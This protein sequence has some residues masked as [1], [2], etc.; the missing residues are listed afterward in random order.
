LKQGYCSLQLD[1]YPSVGDKVCVS[2]FSSVYT[3]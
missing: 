1:K 2:F 3:I